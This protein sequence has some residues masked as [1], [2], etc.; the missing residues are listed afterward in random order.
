MGLSVVHGNR[1]VEASY[2]LTLDEV[3]LIMFA[4]TKFDS[5]KK[6][7]GEIKIYPFEFAE[8]FNLSKQ[9]AH[10]NLVKSIKGIAAK[11]VTIRLDEKKDMVIAWLSMG[12]Y[13][14]QPNDAS[15]VIIEFSKYI[16]PYLFDLKEKFTVLN[17]KYASRLTTPFSF[18][19]YQWLIKSKNLN[20]NKHY[21]T[22]EVVLNLDWIKSQAGLE[23]K[24]ERWVKFKEKVI[25]PA[26][27]QIN[28][29]TDISVV[30]KPIKSGRCVSGIQFNYMMEKEIFSKPIRPRLFRRPK[31][32]KGSHE[33]GVWMRKNLDLLM[34]YAM[35]LKAYDPKAKMDLGDLRK[36]AEYASIYDSVLEGTLRQEIE[37]RTKSLSR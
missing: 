21:E 34:S 20:L 10:R 30:W 11:S 19:L 6:N 9:N 3:R 12:I 24:Y 1:L 22:T 26:V 23:G 8:A 35:E 18:R 36:M 27:T 14:K 37:M 15:H 32:T 17:F 16:E 25:E 5:R 28:R 7:I 13:D 29:K 33:E 2:N 4:A 31:V